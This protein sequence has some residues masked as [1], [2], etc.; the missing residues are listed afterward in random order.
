[1]WNDE[2]MAHLNALFP[3]LCRAPGEKRYAGVG[4]KIRI[5]FL[6]GNIIEINWKVASV[7]HKQEQPTEMHAVLRRAAAMFVGVATAVSLLWR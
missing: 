5:T 3:D 1:M 6:M 4:A 7:K 2:V